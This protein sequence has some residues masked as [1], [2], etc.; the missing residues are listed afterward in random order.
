MPLL[1]LMLSPSLSYDA[2]F[3]CHYFRYERCSARHF[4]PLIRHAMPPYALLS[5]R[6]A[7]MRHTLPRVALPLLHTLSLSPLPR[8][9]HTLLLLLR[10][11]L[12]LR[13]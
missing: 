7:M 2:A 10:R 13:C 12:L 8:A 3:A 9:R 5:P 4:S 11:M 6:H 1:S